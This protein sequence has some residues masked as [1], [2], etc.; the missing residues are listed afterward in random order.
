MVQFAQF[1]SFLL[2]FCISSELWCK[3][4]QQ[5]LLRLAPGWPFQSVQCV[6]IPA[7][8]V[9]W[10][11]SEGA[12]RLGWEQI[13]NSSFLWSPSPR[14]NCVSQ[15]S[16]SISVWTA[17]KSEI[18]SPVSSCAPHSRHILPSRR[19]Q[20]AGETTNPRDLHFNPSLHT[21]FLKVLARYFILSFHQLLQ[22]PVCITVTF[23]SGKC[24][25][26]LAGKGTDLVVADLSVVSD[27]WC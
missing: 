18:S 8:R 13:P 2:L 20:A 14:H 26:A 23:Q 12:G 9:Q 25:R 7:L 11:S 21:G 4:V 3:W 15:I 17:N 22:I 6:K 1:I 5:L 10:V 19:R 24:I 27:T 16:T